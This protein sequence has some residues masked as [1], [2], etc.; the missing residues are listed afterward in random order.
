MKPLHRF[1]LIVLGLAALTTALFWVG[2]RWELEAPQRE[3]PP[4]MVADGAQQRLWV[5]VKRAE[6]RQVGGGRYNSSRWQTRYHF[7][8]H[9]HDAAT[10]ERVSTKR[11]L[12]LTYRQAG[13]NAR[14]RILGQDGKSVWIFLHD[15]P[16]ALSATDGTVLAGP[17][18]IEQ[19]NP[20]LRGVLPAQLGFYAFDRGLVVVSADAQRFVLR[21]ADFAA[22]AYQ[23]VND[24]HYRRIMFDATQWNGGWQNKD[25]VVYSAQLKGRWLG[26]YTPKEAAEA[27][28]D[29]FGSNFA[30]PSRPVISGTMERRAFVGARIG[31]TKEFSE[32]RHDRLFDVTRI[33]DTP[34]FLQGAFMIQQGT[35]T[36]LALK[37][38]DGLLV[39]HRTRAD[40]PGRLAF[41]RVDAALKP[42]W[43]CVLPFAELQNRW[44]TEGHFLMRGSVEMPD[45]S[46]ERWHEYLVAMDLKTGQARGWN[47][48][49]ERAEA[50]NAQG[51]WQPLKG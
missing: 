24:D 20:E 29:G 41:T 2:V 9:M 13:Y 4:A 46:S 49:L 15:K 37:D 22:T 30:D 36:A 16:V 47:V 45:G 25:Y 39:M 7:D 23:P 8:L 27:G 40:A 14:A 18:E 21:G 50:P 42:V 34:D 31:K 44:Q 17:P 5:L 12:T 35:R 26:L 51:E 10:A 3:G 38:P 1:V 32:G 6:H 28:E 11:L 48:T 33:A 19:R 43:R